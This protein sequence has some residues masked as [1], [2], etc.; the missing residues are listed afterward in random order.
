MTVQQR[1]GAGL[2]RVS[3]DTRVVTTLRLPKSQAIILCLTLRKAG[4]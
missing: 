1:A 3:K 2:Q 4:L